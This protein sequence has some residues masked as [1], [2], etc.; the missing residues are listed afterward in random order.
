MGSAS[1]RVLTIGSAMV[2]II[3][4]IANHDVERVTLSNATTSFL[5]VEPGRKIEAESITIHVGGGAVNVGVSIRRQG[6]EVDVLAKLGVDINA[7]RIRAHFRREGLS[8]ERLLISE[9]QPTG[10]SVMIA[11]H[12]RDAAI[13]TQRGANTE[14]TPQDVN[15]CDFSRYGLVYV[16][17]LSKASAECFPVAVSQAHDAGCFTIATPGIRQITTRAPEVI[18]ALEKLDLVVMNMREAEALVP[19]LMTHCGECPVPIALGNEQD[20]AIPVRLA[21]GLRLAD[22]RIPLNW[23]FQSLLST[24][25]KS[26]ALT[27]GGQGSYLCDGKNIYHCPVHTVEVMGTAGAGDAYCSTL[28]YGLYCGKSPETAMRHAAINAAG[29]VSHADTQTGL[30][31]AAT[32]EAQAKAATDLRVAKFSL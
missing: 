1:K 22:E 24:G 7:D 8:E 23:V 28:S 13:Y 10:S 12:D 30:L 25:L 16:S 29:V 19:A 17:P 31:S 15:G 18:N 2:D 21:R 14:L 6:G 27:D 20:P 26:A 5:L 3:T 11:A 9:R 4:I 32:L